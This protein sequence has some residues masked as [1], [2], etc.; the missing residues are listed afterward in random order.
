[1]SATLPSDLTDLDATA[2]SA[3]IHARQLSCVEVMQAYLARIHRLNPRAV[4]MVNLAPDDTLLAQAA[5]CDAELAR[6]HSRGWLHGLPQAIKD[7]SN[8][9]GFPTTFGSPLLLRHMPTED[10]LMTARMKAAGCIVIGKTNMPEFGLGS[11]TFNTPFGATLNAWD[12]AVSAGGSSGGAAVALALRLLP[13]ADGSDFM[14]SLRNPA[15][16]NH[17][18]GFRPSQGRVPFFPVPDVWVNQLGTEGPMARS[19]RD[20]ARLLATQAGPDPRTPLALTE[21]VDEIAAVAQFAGRP[22]AAQ[23]LKGLRIGWLGD[24]GG[25]LPCE[26]GILA[27]LAAYLQT[28]QA[29]GAQVEPTT[30]GCDLDAVWHAW[31][32]WRRAL[33]GPRVAPMLQANPACRAQI[34][35]EVLWEHDNALGLSYM[36]FQRAAVVRSSFLQHMVQ[37]FERFDVLA[38]PTAQ[39]WPFPVGERWPQQIAGRAMD[40]YHRWMECTLYATFAG[41]PALSIPAGFHANGRWPLGLQLM[42]RPRGDAA[43]LRV[44]AGFEAIAPAL[45]AQRPSIALA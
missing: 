45:M 22:E 30:L 40:T 3:A 36:D 13:V 4:A 6:G 24:L 37:Q 33:V 11:H 8:S 35:P 25:H 31:L 10:N 42:G 41:L 7:A 26:D 28:A 44:A 23:S 27:G 32:M 15:G 12:P 5:E 17:V 1:M 14:G 43:L 21:P 34:K 20:L 19:V 9:V 29:A 38:L 39:V 16:W 2:L 18:F